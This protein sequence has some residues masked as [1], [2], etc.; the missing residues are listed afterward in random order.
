MNY[1][2]IKAIDIVRYDDE[3]DRRNQQQQRLLKARAVVNKM[4]CVAV[5]KDE[6]AALGK[7]GPFSG[8]RES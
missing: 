2:N 3:D 5:K 7:L 6:I 4:I 8:I 1:V